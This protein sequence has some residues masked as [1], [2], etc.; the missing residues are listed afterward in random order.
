MNGA[1]LRDPECENL[2]GRDTGRDTL[3]HSKLALL[4]A[5]HRKYELH[6]EQ[7]LEPIRKPHAFSLGSAFQKAIE[8]QDPEAGPMILDGWAF[9]A[10]AANWAEPAEPI[11]FYSQEQEDQHQIDQAILRAAA[12][13]YLRTWPGGS[14]ELRE[15]EYRVRL[16]NPWTGAYSRTF[17]LLGY[18]DGV[19]D[20][21]AQFTDA[22]PLNAALA[23]VMARPYELIENKLVGR[24]DKV[25]VQRLP[26]DRQIGLSRYGL[27]RA[28]G[29]QVEKVSYRWIKKPSIKRRGG[30]KKDKSDAET[31]DQ[32][33]CRI[34]DDYEARP[35]FYLVQEEPQFADPNDLLRIE[36]ELWE[37]A[38]QVRR[39]RRQRLADRNTSHCTD[40]GGCQFMPIC[41]G[42][43][44]APA[45]YRVRPERDETL[46]VPAEADSA[47]A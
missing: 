7:R 28:T 5:C 41:T 23:T 29:R 11:V 13:L 47:A 44:D 38:E 27:W 18:A 17:D 31:L 36:C 3:S 39:L 15:F 46:E 42:D 2:A 8:L 14:A 16:R 25:M 40:Y 30:R 10:A 33:L 35:E 4:L 9:D 26:L 24:V 22:G 6:Y 21:T 32:F 43:P 34:A 12:A 1:I 19:V 37:W 20:S 45:L